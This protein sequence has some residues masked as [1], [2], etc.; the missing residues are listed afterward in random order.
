MGRVVR[1]IQVQYSYIPKSFNEKLYYQD[2]D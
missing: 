2:I 1:V